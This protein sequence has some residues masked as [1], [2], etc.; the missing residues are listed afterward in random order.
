MSPISRCLLPSTLLAVF[1]LHA[2][3]DAGEARRRVRAVASV[4]GFVALWDFVA[5]DPHDGRFT[6]H[7]APGVTHDL[8]LDAMNYVREYWGQGRPAAY[9]DFPLL[10]RGPFGQAVRFLDESDPS[11]R[12]LLLVPRPRMHDSGLDAK[13][14]HRSVSMV[15]WLIRQ[16]GNHAIAGIW[17]EG[18]DLEHAAGRA[19]RVEPGMRQYA[20][21]AGLA[22]NNGASAAHVSENGRNSFGD[23]YARN[24]SVTRDLIP[25]V[26][27]SASGPQLDEAW[28]VVGFSYDNRR[29]TVTSYLNGHAPGYW[30]ANPQTHPFYQW[31]ARAW[32]QAQLRAQPGLQEGEDPAFPADQLYQPPEKKTL[33][34]TL[35]S[36]DGL[37]RVELHEFEFTKVRVTFPKRGGRLDPAAV[38]R[39]LAELRANPFWFGHDLYAPPSAAAGGPFTIGRVIHS[40]RSPGFSGF[41]GGVAVYSR[42]L[43][44]AEMLKLS[45]VAATRARGRWVPAPVDLARP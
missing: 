45:R 5:R 6:A 39:E 25:T 8:R 23:K 7:T 4:P 3:G 26:P 34:R 28:S 17:H 12:P 18:T 2:A 20:L 27:A 11:F 44:A 9:A 42:A 24:L 29:H 43:S 40:G 13:G 21:F 14:P 41:L 22:A 15:V 35:L 37:R 38:T 30:I 1:A 16:G 31:P 10:G 32:L 19:A 33:R 36:E